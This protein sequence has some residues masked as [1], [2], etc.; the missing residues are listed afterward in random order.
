MVNLDPAA[1]LEASKSYAAGVRGAAGDQDP[2]LQVGRLN[3]AATIA[4]YREG[5]NCTACQ[6]L[7]RSVDIVVGDVQGLLKSDAQSQHPPQG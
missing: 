2:R 1:L 7:R 5:C 3:F 4:A 6:L